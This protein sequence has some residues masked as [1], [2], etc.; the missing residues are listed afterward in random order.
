[1][2]RKPFVPTGLYR[3]QLIAERM[4]GYITLRYEGEPFVNHYFPGTVG[5]DKWAALADEQ[6]K[7]AKAA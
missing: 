1:M 5:Y 4:D 7:E 3:R 2:P 6:A